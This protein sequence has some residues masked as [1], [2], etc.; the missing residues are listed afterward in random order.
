MDRFTY[1]C[2]I[3]LVAGPMLASCISGAAGTPGAVTQSSPNAAAPATAS[4]P[5]PAPVAAIMYS[6]PITIS[7][8]GIYSGNW[9]STEDTVAS[10]TIATTD[11]VTIENCYLKG[12]SNQINN[13]VK[14]VN[15]TIRNCVAQGTTPT[16][17][18]D[19]AGRFVYLDTPASLTVEHNTLIGTS[20]ILVAYGNAPSILIRYNKAFNID[21]RLS[22]GAGGYIADTP[23]T[24]W[25]HLVQFA[26]LAYVHASPNVEVAWNEVINEIG[27]S[28]VEDNVS[29]FLSSGT[30]ANPLLVHDNYIQGAF[31]V[32]P[33]TD[34]NYNGGGILADGTYSSTVANETGFVHVLDNQIVGGTNYCVGIASGHD[35]LV[36][37]NRCVASGRTPAGQLML[38]ANLGVL[39]WDAYG[40]IARGT[41]Y[42]NTANSNSVAWI[43]KHGA[44]SDFYTPNCMAGG[45]TSNDHLSITPTLADEAAEY[46]VWTAKKTANSVA[47]GSTLPGG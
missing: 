15:L 47:V 17:K 43:N 14:N 32:T 7:S 29:I 40:D 16:V 2:L 21:G 13:S 11:P 1:I 27:K 25:R 26:Q 12:P 42:N 44:R 45:C 19:Y 37:G 36:S 41:W 20:G 35:I 23:T 5:A 9:E 33:L 3:A 24:T 4:I 30:A 28:A 38:A 34:G 31:P 46:V 22:N 18:G 8:G 39:V 6:A 10:V